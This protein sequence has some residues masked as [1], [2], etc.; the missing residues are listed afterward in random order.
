MSNFDTDINSYSFNEL[1]T[2]LNINL[3][4]EF[5]NELLEKNYSNKINQLRN[6][7]D[8]SLAGDLNIFFTKIYNLL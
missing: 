4:V 5:T 2:L 3:N 7:D 8:T 1:K 6:L